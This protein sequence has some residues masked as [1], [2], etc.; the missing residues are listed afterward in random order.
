ME[1]Y[2]LE[3]FVLT[4]VEKEYIKK[5]DGFDFY[6]AYTDDVSVYRAAEKHHNEQT[7]QGDKMIADKVRLKF[8]NENKRNLLHKLKDQLKDQEKDKQ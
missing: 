6:Y 3:N 2:T 5:Y 7:E 4:D 1:N 8:I